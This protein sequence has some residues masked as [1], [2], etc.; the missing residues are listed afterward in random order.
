MVRYLRFL[1]AAT[2]VPL[3][4]GAQAPAPVVHPGEVY[5]AIYVDVQ[6]GSTAAAA[7]LLKQYRDA[8]RKD[9]GN[10]RAEVAQEVNR[11][12][13]FAV[14]AVWADQ[15]AWEAHGKAA[16]TMQSREKLAAIQAG[17]ADERV[18][19]GMFVGTK[20]APGPGARFVLTHVDVPPPLK[21]TL[22]PM[23][24]QLGDDSRGA[25]GNQRWEAQQQNNRPNHFTV[26]EVWANPKAYEAFIGTP[27]KRQ[28]REKF[29]PM[30][31]ALYD[32]RLYQGL[33]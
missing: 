8:S 25:A 27:S 14:L 17:P 16:H 28:F 12:N 13:R 33:K 6:P 2:A 32:E 10:L 26:V 23:L 20:T 21:D 1:I 4:A 9:E 11:P 5:V 15:K 24:K 29:G 3:V 31:G 18:H 30:T 22:I 19:N 7:G